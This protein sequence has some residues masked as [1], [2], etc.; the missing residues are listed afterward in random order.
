MPGTPFKVGDRITLKKKHPCGGF[1]WEIYRIG[2]D[3]GMKCLTCGRR[4]MLSRR[5]AERRTVGR[6]EAKPI[7]SA[8]ESELSADS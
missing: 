4:M 7:A 2:A 5:N 8:E 3:I 1:D 6:V